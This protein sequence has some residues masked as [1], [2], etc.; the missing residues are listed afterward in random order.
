MAWRADKITELMGQ[1]VAGVRSVSPD[2]VISLSPNGPGFAYRKYLQ[3]WLTWVDQGFLDE[4]IVQ[5][6][7][8]DIGALEAELYG[9]GFRTVDPEIPVAIGLYTGPAGQAKPA[10]QIAQEVE[11]VQVAGYDGVA[12]FCWETTLWLLKQS[13]TPQVYTLFMERFP[14]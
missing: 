10:D 6:Y 2:L 5:V 3:D 13:P 7:R 11:A 14:E 4:V 12:F 9:G 8:E 1:I